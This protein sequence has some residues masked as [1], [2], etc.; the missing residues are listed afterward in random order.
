VDGGAV[1]NMSP[2]SL[3]FVA[4]GLVGDPSKVQS[5][6]KKLEALAEQ[7][8]NFPGIQWDADSHGEI[9]FHTI[10]VP[11]PD[12]QAQQLLGDTMEIAVGT[13]G[14]SAFFAIGKNAVA[15]TKAII[16][17]SEAN[18]GKQVPPFEL[19]A[20]LGKILGTVAK[21][22]PNPVVTRVAEMLESEAQGRDHVK[23]VE[24]IV[25]NGVKVRI[26][27]EEGV[28]R[29]IGTAVE[30]GQKAAQGGGF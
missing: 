6:L 13:G 18:S 8:E 9:K 25:D 17:A 22:D 15:A 23:I 12:P 24:H 2:D 16:D 14:K 28:L 21:I 30:E 4:G 27:L 29:A 7:D 11:V 1:L 20:S 26:E 5:G 19:T 10:D 3:T